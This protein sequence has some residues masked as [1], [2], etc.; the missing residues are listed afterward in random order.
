MKRHELT[1]K[2][3]EKVKD[4]LPPE[5]KPQG[6]RPA[7]DNRVMLNGIIYWLATGVP[8]RD[9]PE[10]FGPWETVYGRFRTWTLQGVWEDVMAALIEQDIVDEST[11]MLDSTT[12]KVHQHA[13]GSKKGITKKRPGVAGAD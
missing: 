4:L 5:R 6:G 11:L 3:W 10:R 9:L 7:K 2:Q 1:E 12:V 8:W 13:S